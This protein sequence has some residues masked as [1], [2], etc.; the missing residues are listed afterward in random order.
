[1]FEQSQLMASALARAGKPY[2]LVR[3]AGEDH[4]LSLGETRLN[5]LSAAISFVE[6]H[7]PPDAAPA[8]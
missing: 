2:E 7:N 5:M 1:L 4:W 8:P 3:L 6:K